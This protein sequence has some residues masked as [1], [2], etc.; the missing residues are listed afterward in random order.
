MSSPDT[1]NAIKASFI[2]PSEDFQPSPYGSG[3]DQLA[4]PANIRMPPE[5]INL[6]VQTYQTAPSQQSINVSVPQTHFR[7]L[8]VSLTAQQLGEIARFK[9]PVGL[10]NRTLWV[11]LS[12][13]TQADIRLDIIF[14]LGG[15]KVFE[16][17]HWARTT[18][19]T[20]PGDALA[21]QSAGAVGTVEA[22]RFLSSVTGSAVILHPFYLWQA[23]DELILNISLNR[24]L[25]T[26][27]RVYFAM[28]S[29]NKPS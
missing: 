2:V 27:S 6:P 25:T 3:P 18:N 12:M 14:M 28:R 11:F 24:D 15:Q 26:D 22:I 5:G 20:G 21:L 17:A 9:V 1:N 29:T 10:P 19:T 8:Q 16:I 23:A 13:T 4:L 7:A